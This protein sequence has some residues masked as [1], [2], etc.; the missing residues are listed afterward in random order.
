M[1]QTLPPIPRRVRWARVATLV[2]ALM[3]IGIMVRARCEQ[4]ERHGQQALDHGLDALAATLLRGEDRLAD[5]EQAFGAAARESLSDP[6]PLFCLSAVG[7]L[8]ES[9]RDPAAAGADGW[10]TAMTQLSAGRLSEARSLI[11]TLAESAADPGQARRAALYVRLIDDL[12][13]R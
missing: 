11:S 5:A 8:R 12:A 9:R 6:Y 1:P 7:E 3:L 2:A 4:M 13:G 10:P